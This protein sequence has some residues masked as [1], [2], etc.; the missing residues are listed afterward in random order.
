MKPKIHP[1]L[2]KVH[3]IWKQIKVL[4]EED[5]KGY[6]SFM[7][8]LPNESAA[9]KKD[10]QVT[11]VKG[12]IN[13]TGMLLRA[14]GDAVF[15]KEIRREKLK[16]GQ[17]AFIQE[18]DR[19]KQSLQEMMHNEVA[20]SLAGYGT[21][22]AVM[23]KPNVKVETLEQEL[24]D[25]KPFLTILDPEQVIDFE[26]AKDGSLEWFQYNV[27][28]PMDRSDPWKPKRAEG[29]K[30]DKGIAT[31]TKTT[32]TVR[33]AT[34]ANQFFVSL[35]HSFGFVPVII[36]AQFVEPNKTVGASTFFSSSDYLIMGNNLDGASNLEVFKNANST[37]TMD[38]QDWDDD[39]QPV[40]IKSAETNLRVLNKQAHDFKNVFLYTKNKPEF[41]TRDLDLIELAAGRAKRYFDL[42]IENEKNALSVG[43]QDKPQSGVAKSMDFI[44]VNNVLAAAAAALQRFEVQ[45]IRMAGQLLDEVDESSVVYPQNF[46][47]RSFNERLEYI[48]GLIEAKYP[49]QL[50]MKEAYKSLT[51]EI[52]PVEATQAE[53]NKEID[54]QHAPAAVKPA[55]LSMP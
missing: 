51:P 9:A 27:D 32:F 7:I 16:P 41:M 33:S 1:E 6:E 15:K 10:R 54:A 42:A 49:S 20:P 19:S 35:T 28:A 38:V 14:K 37:L 25:G 34:Q 5:R 29:W 40:H 22:F 55:P 45:V 30:A 8:P 13:P 50:G 18:A 23:D 24:K 26:W 43:N 31:W 44:D 21:V 4:K 36:Q 52:S 17:E 12:F 3:P 2:A 53:I 48:K 39:Q 46:D 11:F 47:T